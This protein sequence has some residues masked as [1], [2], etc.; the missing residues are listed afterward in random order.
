MVDLVSVVVPLYNKERWISRAVQ[1]VLAQ[2]HQNF[3]L[4]VVDDGSTDNGA[5]IVR[6]YEDSRIRIISKDNGGVSSARNLGIKVAIGRFIAFL[7]ADDEWRPFHLEVLIKG[8]E[9]NDGVVAVCDD[10]ALL[11]G[12]VSQAVSNTELFKELGSITGYTFYK[13]SIPKTLSRDLFVPNSSC[14]VVRTQVLMENNL[15]FEEG[16]QHG[17]DVNFWIK[18]GFLGGFL[19]CDYPGAVYHRDDSGSLMNLKR[20]VA[21][22]MPDYLKGV[23]LSKLSKSEVSDLMSF[24]R[25]EGLKAAYQNRGLPLNRNELEILDKNSIGLVSKSL[26]V[27]VR[28]CPNFLMEISKSFKSFVFSFRL[29]K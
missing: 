15:F 5:E 16:M 20:Q 19:Y 12:P 4:I 11:E 22:P 17:E 26:Y 24:L 25:L 6:G 8:F 23:Y 14:T 10:H 21:K 28:F 13:F 27:Y 1:S 9:L 29:V 3:E 7:D 2:T 18:I